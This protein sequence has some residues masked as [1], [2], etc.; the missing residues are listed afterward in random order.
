MKVLFAVPYIYDKQYPEFTKNSTGFG[1]LMAQIYGFVGKKCNA[2]LISHVLTKGYGNILR[3]TL[4]DVICHIRWRDLMQGI[5]W[6]I[7]YNQPLSGRLRY[8]YYCI[9]K[10][11]VRHTIQRL[12]PDIVHINGVGLQSKP[13]IEVC[14]ELG[15]EYAVT[16]HGLIG[17]NDSVKTPKWNKEHEKE[18]LLECE[19]NQIPV[20]VISTGMKK[21][22]EEHYLK[23]ESQMINVVT[24][25][26]N[27]EAHEGSPYADLRETYRIPET[28]RIAVS[29]GNISLRKNQIQIVEA[30]DV[31]LKRGCSDLYVFL[32]GAEFDGGAVKRRITE[33]G[34]E[35]R[36]IP[37]GFVPYEQ[38]AGVFHQAEMTILASIDE[39]FGLSIIEGFVH[40]LPAVTFADLDAVPDLY[41]EKAMVLSKDRSTEGLA[42]AIDQ[43]LKTS[44]D[45]EWIR[46]YSKQFSLEEMAKKYCAVYQSAVEK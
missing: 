29:V 19:K 5:C 42:S 31:L 23:S 1:I 41:H 16:L 43:A 39:G 32:C 34:L 45:S 10:G 8:L 11:Y 37:L 20:T 14:K 30:V 46:G 38:M 9:N 26:T 33:L 2:Y 15:V 21:R 22:I 17:L 24:N 25:G 27:V 12:R 7:K 4:G 40:G 18:V 44:W 28:G 3:H 35:D 13:Y 36:I 6:A